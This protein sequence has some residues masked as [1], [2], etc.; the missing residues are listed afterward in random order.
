MRH[1]RYICI[2][3]H[4]Y[5][6][7]RENPWLGAVEI[8]DSAA[9]FHD[10][11]ERI[12]HECYAPNARAR[13][14]DGQGR[15]INLV[16]NY[17]WMSFNFG[18]TLLHWMAESAPAALAGIVEADRLSQERRRGHGN[19]LA[20]VYNHM[21]LPLASARDKVTQVRWGMADF[22]HRFGREPEGMWL[23]ETAVDVKSLEV[24][25]EAGIRFT[26]LAPRQA[27]RWRRLGE[28]DWPESTG[29][30]DPSRAYLA[31]LPSGRSIS[32]FFYDGIIS[33]QVAF[34]RL[35]DHGDR[36]VS[37]LYQGFDSQR[38]QAQLM[39]IATDGESYGHHH[40]HGDM[41][42]AYVLDRLARDPEVRLTNYGEFLELHPPEWEVEIH[43]DS[44]WS[45]V[46]GV[47]RW[48]SD[49]GCKSR[50]E[51]HQQWRGPLRDSLN[52][53]KDRLD[54]LFSTRGREC[55]PNPWAA[56]DAYIDVVLDRENPQAVE[57]FLARYGHADLDEAQ[58]TSALR[59]LEMQQDAMLMF[60]SCGWFF[61]EISGLETVQCL[62]YAARAIGIARQFHRDFEAPFVEGLAK[63]PSN[64]PR[65]RDGAGVWSQVVRPADVDLERV[66]AH[67]AISLIFDPADGAATRRVY[68]YDVENLDV[69]M[70]TRGTG[71]LAVGRLRARSR[72]TRTEAETSFV[73]VHFGG[74][75][76][77][78]VLNNGTHPEVF[79][80]LKA[81]LL[82]AYRTGSLADVMA[83]VREEFPG[84][85]HRLDDLFRDE[86]RRIIGIVLADRFEDYQRAFEHLANQDEE[87]LNRLGNLN[88]PVP[89]SLRAAA[90]TCI[91]RHLRDQVAR[92]ERGEE[93]NLDH[94]EQIH[95]RGRA[96]GYQPQR[97]VLEKILGEALERTLGALGPD[98]DPTAVAARAGLL[99]DASRLLDVRPPMWQAQ[100][101]LLNRF[102]ELSK[103]NGVEPRLA[104]TFADLA[105]RLQ[106][107]PSLLGWR[108]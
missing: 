90:S 24:L 92:L 50:G 17:A 34:E 93:T 67:H 105:G 80:L 85:P 29:G 25:A 103:A 42:L 100:N 39:H 98:S 79:D 30:V 76:F 87:I 46:H 28:T 73:V 107:S 31:R 57:T 36:F 10:W 37:R 56:R 4:F 64:I 60:T 47:E 55:F 54:H 96:W 94:L 69:E 78:A 38:E 27:K 15:I 21:I 18:P 22:R 41:A 13:L 26:I 99:L 74:L 61:D 108:P 32:L 40:A 89:R 23:A 5:Q 48:R 63:A 102:H 91:D 83:L 12:T 65:F 53:L 45:C 16:N 35:L 104:T 9:P 1:P 14:L 97:E 58:A 8:Q 82:A 66:F 51:W 19:A 62:N 86:Q 68:S 81:R 2:H 52:Q 33:Q 101:V 77:H 70:R 84:R 95:E 75:D 7:P 6:P 59:L 72:R 11:N 71:H 44:S 88:Y 106:L 49:C 43:D 3:G 20:Q